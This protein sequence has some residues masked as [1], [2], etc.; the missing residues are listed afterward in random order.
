MIYQNIYYDTRG[1]RGCDLMVVEFITTYVISA[2]HH[3]VGLTTTYV[4]TAT[5]FQLYHGSQFY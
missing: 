5:T 1:R 2:Y 3:L 4:I